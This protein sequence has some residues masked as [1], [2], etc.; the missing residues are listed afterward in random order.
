MLLIVLDSDMY[1][2]DLESSEY[3]FIK[4]KII[5]WIVSVLD[6]VSPSRYLEHVSILDGVLETG[7]APWQQNNAMFCDFVM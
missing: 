3:S 1:A 7:G 6:R 4:K 5:V 2:S